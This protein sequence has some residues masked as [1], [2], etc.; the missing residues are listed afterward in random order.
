MKRI[1]NIMVLAPFVFLAATCVTDVRQKG[2]AGP[3]VGEV[4]NYSNGTVG[5]GYVESPVADATGQIVTYVQSQPCP[6]VLGPG[7]SAAFELRVDPV[8]FS[9]SYSPQPVLP[10]RLADGPTFTASPIQQDQLPYAP[11]RALSST[12][13]RSVPAQD[14][15]LVEVRNES[16]FDLQYMTLCAIA[17]SPDGAVTAVGIAPPII[18]T[19]GPGD[20]R[21]VPVFFSSLPNGELEIIGEGMPFAGCCEVTIDP[22]GA[23]SI[24]ASRIVEDPAG[25]SLRVFGEMR[26]N[27]GR[28]LSSVELTAHLDDDWRARVDGAGLGCD[29]PVAAGDTVPIYLSFPVQS[30]STDRRLEVE[31]FHAYETASLYRVPTSNI[32]LGP[33]RTLP[34]AGIESRSVS[35]TFANDSASWIQVNGVCISL[36]DRQGRLTGAGSIYIGQNIAPG[37]SIETEADID[38]FDASSTAEVIAY[39]VPLLEPPPGVLPI[40]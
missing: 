38:Q 8:A 16:L 35:M 34:G 18:G 28:D 33:V 22:D 36:R 9:G 39:A 4:V 6:T 26:N 24:L 30:M 17:R 12:V 11:R 25:P 1:R 20:K 15:A 29:G 3:W 13:V 23:L 2:E 37:E 5:Y 14:L 40:P 10:L 7:E 21:I 31:H 32:I 27:T 19:L